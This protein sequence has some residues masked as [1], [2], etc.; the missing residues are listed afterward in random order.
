MT[1]ITTAAAVSVTLSFGLLV[2]LDDSLIHPDVSNGGS[3]LFDL[4]ETVVP[5]VQV[6]QD[7]VSYLW[8]RPALRCDDRQR[9][10]TDAGGNILRVFLSSTGGR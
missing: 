7:L 6:P 10:N 9:S 3:H 8:R 4:H 2:G 5:S 1:A